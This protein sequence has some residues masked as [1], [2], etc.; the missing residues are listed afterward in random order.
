MSDKI[1]GNK[2]CP[3]CGHFIK[4]SK[5]GVHTCSSCTFRCFGEDFPLIAT[6]MELARIESHIDGL[7][8]TVG[9]TAIPTPLVERRDNAYN[10]MLQAWREE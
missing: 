7:D 6:A 5:F 2:R 1:Q 4:I 9:L 8:R 10:A 3:I